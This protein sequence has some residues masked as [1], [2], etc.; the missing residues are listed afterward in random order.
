M[1]SAALLKRMYRYVILGGR[2]VYPAIRHP[3][4]REP[5]WRMVIGVHYYRGRYEAMS[6]ASCMLLP[7]CDPDAWAEQAP[8]SVTDRRGGG[9]RRKPRRP[10]SCRKITQMHS[11][12]AWRWLVRSLVGGEACGDGGRLPAAAGNVLSG[13]VYLKA[14]C[15]V[16]EAIKALFSFFRFFPAAVFPPLLSYCAS[17]YVIGDA[18]AKG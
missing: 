6:G 16:E 9:R 18:P 13:R 2:V 17:Y 5:A 1:R 11:W 14:P 7:L 15:R 3:H 10:R 12:L 8:F 4:P